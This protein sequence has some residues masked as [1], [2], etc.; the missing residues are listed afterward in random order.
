MITFGGQKY[1]IPQEYVLSLLKEMERPL[2]AALAKKNG[3]ELPK[4]FYAEDG[5][6]D[7]GGESCGRV[8]AKKEQIARAEA[9]IERR[10][11]VYS[12]GLSLKES[13][14]A[15]SLESDSGQES[16]GA[17]FV[18]IV[19]NYESGDDYTAFCY[20]TTDRK[21][22]LRFVENA[23]QKW[24]EGWATHA[25]LW[26]CA[27]NLWGGEKILW[28]VYSVQKGEWIAD[29]SVDENETIFFD[30]EVLKKGPHSAPNVG[31]FV[32]PMTVKSG[33]KYYCK[34]VE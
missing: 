34:F 11:R 26:R 13:K 7:N 19:T 21:E 28:G 2:A 8:P 12:R 14:L 22:A 10:L 16:A 23:R 32:C 27:L 20:G 3:L 1:D 9:F 5:D 31:T 4:D 17:P 30:G 29:Y 25:L 24:T 18:Y 15:A 6:G 33:K